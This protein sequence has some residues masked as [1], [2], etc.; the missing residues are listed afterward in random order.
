[1]SDG[2]YVG[3]VGGLYFVQGIHG[4]F[5]L[6]QVTT[7]MVLPG[8]DVMVPVDL[9]HPNARNGPMPTGDALMVMTNDGILACFDGGNAFNLTHD[10]HIFPAG[11]SAAALYRHDTGVSS[12]VAA[13]DSAGG[14]SS[15]TRIGDYVDAEIIRAS[16]SQGG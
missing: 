13:V 8:S 2:L 14:P 15:N 1:M 9:V 11:V 3:T 6:Q 12:Y 16:A 4:K 10:R 5:Q 7:S